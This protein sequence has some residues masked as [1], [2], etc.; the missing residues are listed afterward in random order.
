MIL[1][2]DDRQVPLCDGVGED[3]PRRFQGVDGLPDMRGDRVRDGIPLVASTAGRIALTRLAMCGG[4]VAPAAS[5][6]TVAL[7]APQ[8][9][10]PSTTMSGELNLDIFWL[11]DSS[12]DDPDTLPPPDEIAAEIAESL[13]AALA[14]FRSVASRLA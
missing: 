3:R 5:V 6:S 2:P 10:C 13:E 8:R 1:R 11:K 14:R 7:T 4:G 12:L 9:S